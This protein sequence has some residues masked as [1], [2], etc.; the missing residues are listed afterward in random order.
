M[1]SSSSAHS[2]SAHSVPVPAQA[3]KLGDRLELECS[4]IAFGGQVT[5]CLA[6]A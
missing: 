2:R 5:N 6:V 3:P 4:S 1:T